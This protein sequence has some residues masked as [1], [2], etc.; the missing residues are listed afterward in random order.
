MSYLIDQRQ[1][2]RNANKEFDKNLN[3]KKYDEDVKD[4]PQKARD[5]YMDEMVAENGPSL[6]D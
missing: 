3:Q 2:Y 4:I 5:K 6:R 1:K